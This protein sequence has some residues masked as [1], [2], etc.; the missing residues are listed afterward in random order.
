MKFEGTRIALL[1]LIWL[2]NFGRPVGQLGEADR[3]FTRPIFDP[4][5]TGDPV[6]CPVVVAPPSPTC[7]IFRLF[8]IRYRQEAIAYPSNIPQEW[9]SPAV[10]LPGHRLSQRRARD[11]SGWALLPNVRPFKLIA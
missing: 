8:P 7:S 11:T 4:L 9:Y 6:R 1:S 10:K 2:S 5:I 3:P